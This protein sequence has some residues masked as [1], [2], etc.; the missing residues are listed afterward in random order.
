[1]SM[2]DKIVIVLKIDGKEF[3]EFISYN[4]VSDLYEAADQFSFELIPGNT[5]PAEGMK[6]QMFVNDVLELTGFI[7]NVRIGYDGNGKHLSITGRD[8]MGI[9]VDSYCEK[10]ETIQNTTVMDVAK[11]LLKKFPFITSFEFDDVADKRD[12]SKPYI[13]IEPGQRIFDVL[14]DIAASRGLCFYSNARGGLVFRKPQGKGRTRFKLFNDE[15]QNNRSIASCELVKDMSQRYSQYHVLSQ[16]QGSDDDT[17]I[18]SEFTVTDSPF[19]GNIYKP[20]V[21]SISDDKGSC[22]KRA[23]F[24]LEQSRSRSRL[25]EYSVYGHSQGQYNW[26]IDELVRVDDDSV[27][28]HEEML[29]YSRTFIMSGEQQTT[30]L[31]LGKPG[32]IA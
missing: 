16:E 20:Y 32:L 12:K 9:I 21:E 25:V 6:C 3:K 4:V 23:K 22:E 17:V 29:V 30:E 11:K 5:I 13:Q 8:T 14:A 24:L 2:S 10:F 28:V 7:D 18:N 26:A 27:G 31:R 15:D 1:M 19:P